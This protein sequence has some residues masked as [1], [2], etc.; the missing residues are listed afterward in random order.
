MRN[1]FARQQTAN[2]AKSLDQN[3]NRRINAAAPARLLTRRQALAGVTAAFAGIA[4]GSPLR[5]QGQ[6]QDAKETPA[7]AANKT[8]TFLH[9]ETSFATSPHRLYKL[10]LDSK[11]FA[12]FTK[13]KARIDPKVGGA[14]SMFDGMIVGRNVELIPDQRIVQ[15]WRP[16]HWDSG[17]YS[18]VKFELKPLGSE[19]T[20]VLDHTGFPQG[21]YDHLYPGWK[22][23]YWDPIKKY[24]AK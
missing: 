6:P 1:I 11:N 18:I 12:A 10:L 9:Q 17:V 4:L 7:A 21:E 24:L 14:F 15:A 22:L 3:S 19:T 2:A 8:T 13:M 23:R 5:S 16:T 20:L